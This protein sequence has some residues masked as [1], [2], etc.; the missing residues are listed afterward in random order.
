M[1]L[2]QVA[3][4][5]EYSTESWHLEKQIDVM[6]HCYKLGECRTTQYCMVRR[7][8]IS[9]FK[10]DEL[11]TIILPRAEGDWEDYR[12]KRVCHVTW[13]DAVEG[14]LTGNQHAL[15]IQA[16]FFQSADED[17]IEPAPA[18]DEDL[19]ELDLR[20]HRIKDQREFSGLR[21]ARPLVVAGELDGDLRPTE[22][23]WYRRLDKQDL[24]EKQLLVP[25][26]AKILVS[27]EDDVDHL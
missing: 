26:G 24:P 14:G 7:L 12:T 21:E 10:F 11:S 8:E 1:R 20:H 15:E 3:M 22:R 13:D 6:R 18:I 4:E 9:H 27:P 5:S 17:E 25:P 2:L 16:H 19:G 23:S